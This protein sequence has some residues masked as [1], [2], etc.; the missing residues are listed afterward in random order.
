M[1]ILLFGIIGSGKS[2]IGKLLAEKLGY[3]FVEID[4]LVLEQTGFSSAD[5]I[6]NGGKLIWKETELNVVKDLSFEDNCVIACSGGFLE[7]ELNISYFKENSIFKA[8]YLHANL[9]VLTKRISDRNKL[10]GK[11]TDEIK[12]K[13]AIKSLIEKRDLDYKYFSDI[14]IDTGIFSQEEVVSQICNIVGFASR[15]EAN[16][17]FLYEKLLLLSINNESGRIYNEVNANI[18]YTLLASVL[19]E[20]E[21]LGILSIVENNVKIEKDTSEFT[22]PIFHYVYKVISKSTSTRLATQVQDLINY[23]GKNITDLVLSHLTNIN[24]LKQ[25]EINFFLLKI[26]NKYIPQNNKIVEELKNS[27]LNLSNQSREE[28][29]ILAKLIKWLKLDNYI[30]EKNDYLEFSEKIKNLEMENNP[31]I[32]LNIL[33]SEINFASYEMSMI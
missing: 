24:E 17:F 30:F 32:N 13:L 9:E 7:N 29:I 8:V 28:D 23:Q 10:L 3:K 27:I 1:N 6:R 11:S 31:I 2:S 16:E 22:D 15:S 12:L 25:E 20:M 26:N 21:K 19:I 4:N 14:S 5:E 18:S 33:M